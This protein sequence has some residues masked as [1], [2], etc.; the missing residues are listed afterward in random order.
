MAVRKLF[1]LLKIFYGC[2]GLFIKFYEGYPWGGGREIRVLPTQRLC[3]SK[4]YTSYFLVYESEMTP[5]TYMSFSRSYE[6]YLEQQSNHS[7][8][9]KIEVLWPWEN[10][11]SY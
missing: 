8:A 5:Y 10:C 4:V 3:P 9:R 2:N 1:F 6:L 11:F 7:I